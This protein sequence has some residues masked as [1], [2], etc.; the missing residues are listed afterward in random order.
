[1][2]DLKQFGTER[3]NRGVDMQVKHPKTG[4][5][6]IDEKTKE[7]VTITLLGQDCGDY[8]ARA[9]EIANKRIVISQNKGV[10]L[11][12]DAAE[13]ERESLDLLVLLTKDWK[14]LDWDGKEL[15]CT[16][17]NVEMVYKELPWLREQ[18]DEFVGDRGNFL[19]NS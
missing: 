1:M 4:A 17:E 8:K 16:P 6:M 19:G 10:K 2:P 9:H 11:R 12:V 7:P 14:H 15:D 3:A 18:V 5:V 13:I